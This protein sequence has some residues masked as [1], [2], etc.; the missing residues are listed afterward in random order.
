MQ[1]SVLVFPSKEVALS[2][3]WDTLPSGN[4]RERVC[5]YVPVRESS[6]RGKHH[7]QGW[8]LCGGCK[9][10]TTYIYSRCTHKT[11]GLQ[12]QFWFCNPTMVEGSKCVSKHI[13]E[14][15]RNK[16]GGGTAV[17][18]TRTMM[19]MHSNCIKIKNTLYAYLFATHVVPRKPR[20]GTLIHGIST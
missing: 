2:T 20:K 16:R 11:D 6:N 12:K 14:K 17:M 13:E 10:Q 5:M 18:M 7:A 3:C 1:E 15:H 19:T 8:C 9:K 4:L